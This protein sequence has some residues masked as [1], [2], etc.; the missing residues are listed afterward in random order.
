MIPILDIKRQF[1]TPRG[2]HLGSLSKLI[3]KLTNPH[4]RETTNDNQNKD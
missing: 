4:I 3:K 2:I 1:H